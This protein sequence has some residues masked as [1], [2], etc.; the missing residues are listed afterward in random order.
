MVSSIVS[1]YQAANV[2]FSAVP[3]A[4]TCGGKADGGYTFCAPKRGGG[5]FFIGLDKSSAPENDLPAIKALFKSPACNPAPASMPPGGSM[6]AGSRVYVVNS[7]LPAFVRE[8]AGRGADGVGQNCYGAALFAAGYERMKGR[9]ADPE[10]AAYY[11][12]RDYS[13]APC[14]SKRAMGNIVIYS[15]SKSPFDAGEHAAFELPGG[16]VFH[17]GGWKANYPY[18]IVLLHGAMK[19]I[20]AHYL[21]TGDERFGPGPD[22]SDYEGFSPRCYSQKSALMK[23]KTSSTRQDRMWFLPLMEH[24][25]QGLRT[26]AGFVWGE[27]A[28]NRM[29]LLS[30]E[31]M[32]RVLRAFSN[33]LGNADAQRALLSL[34]D[35]VA[36]AYLEL[37]S[38]SWQHGAMAGTYAPISARRRGADLEKLYR[39]HYMRFDAEFSRETM[40]YLKLLR[41]PVAFRAAV[42]KSFEKRLREYD[43]AAFASSDGARGIPYMDELIKV[44]RGI[45]KNW[46]PPAEAVLTSN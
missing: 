30:V 46:K 5:D 9:Y 21:P 15:R 36:E 38:L 20:L 29:S 35:G 27:F 26:A 34:D 7:C 43:P 25:S 2:A 41:V 44:I 12:K 8:W 10:E 6:P 39:E 31:N 40:L 16:L 19:A 3:D 1:S 13:P 17:K 28:K 42:Q 22:P 18:E 32:W 4:H 11:L 14:M 24:Y 45:V 33:R 23:R 37:K